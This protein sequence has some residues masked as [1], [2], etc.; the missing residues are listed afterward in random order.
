MKNKAYFGIDPGKSGFITAFDGKGFKFYQMPTH[1]VD[2]GELLKSGKPKMKEVFNE[3]GF[4]ELIL[5]IA[6]D[7]KGYEKYFAIEEVT[8]RQGWSAQNNFN[9]G[10]VAGLQRMIPIMM[11]AEYITVRPNKWQSYMRKGYKD[12]KKKSSSGKTMVMDA[13]TIAEKIVETEYPNI[14]FRKTERAKK[15]DD[16]KIDSFLICIYLYRILNN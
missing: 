7:F 3:I 9:F 4:V 11:C 6:S 5:Q 10:F 14:D 13:K 8:G 12:I 16:N 15:N 1:K 2:T